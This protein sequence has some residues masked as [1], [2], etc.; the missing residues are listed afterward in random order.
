MMN[1]YGNDGWGMTWLGWTMM[2]VFWGGLIGLG[3]WVVARITRSPQ[4]PP[5]TETPRQILDRR[6]AAG[7]IDTEQYASARH[8]IE[9]RAASG[10]AVKP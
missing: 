7:E 9:G 10:S 4:Q 3:I 2:V 6:L 5:Q 8:L 1:W